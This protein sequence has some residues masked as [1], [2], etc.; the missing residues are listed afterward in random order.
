M[1]KFNGCHSEKKKL[2]DPNLIIQ[3]VFELNRIR[4]YLKP[5]D[6]HLLRLC[7]LINQSQ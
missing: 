6:A 7:F 2:Q 1:M 4:Y 3:S 5:L